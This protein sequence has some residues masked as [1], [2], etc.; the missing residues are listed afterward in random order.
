MN[1]ARVLG[2]RGQHG[3]RCHHLDQVRAVAKLAPSRGPHRIG[4]IGDLVHPWV[5]VGRRRGDRQQAAGQEHSRPTNRARLNRGTHRHFDVVPAADVANC[6]DAGEQRTFRSCRSEQGNLGIG[7]RS[8]GP[9][10]A[11]VGRLR[12]VHMAID[13]TGD[14]PQTTNIDDLVASRPL[15]ALVERTNSPIR[16]GD[17]SRAKRTRVDVVDLTTQQPAHGREE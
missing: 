13:Q 10:I 5:I 9:R 15:G 2:L 11:I 12:D 14:Q 4:S 8:S 7:A 17:I 3:T 16:D 6:R 1:R